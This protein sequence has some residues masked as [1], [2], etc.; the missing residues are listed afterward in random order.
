MV[1]LQRKPTVDDDQDLAA[2]SSGLMQSKRRRSAG[3]ILGLL[4]KLGVTW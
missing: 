1:R 2:K 3:A 4:N